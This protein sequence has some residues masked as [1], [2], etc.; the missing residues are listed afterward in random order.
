MPESAIST[1]LVDFAVPVEEMGAKLVEFV[2]GAPLDRVANV[3]A[4]IIES[5]TVDQTVPEICAILRNR[6]GHDFSGYKTR[7][8]VRRV[9]RRMQVN[10]IGTLDG[11][12]NRLRQEPQEVRA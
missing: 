3:P 10:Q 11:Y 2:R 9:Q 5:Q 8:F 6:I 12:I 4:E 1:G 7:S